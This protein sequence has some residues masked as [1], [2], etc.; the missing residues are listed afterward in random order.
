M[1][2][3]ENQSAQAQLRREVNEL[4]FRNRQLNLEIHGVPLVQGENLHNVLNGVADQL[5]TPHL[6]EHD[7]ASVHRLPAQKDKI[8][9]IIV[10]FTRQS[11]RESWLSK[12]SKLNDSH[13]RIFIQENLTRHN[14]DLLQ[15]T[16][17]WAKE[18]GFKYVWHTHGK[19]LLRM[20]DGANAIHIRSR[21]DL[22]RLLP[23]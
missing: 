12:K 2:E 3:D 6:V 10:R 5:E 13:P 16:K 7:I 9:G 8:P 19:V 11:T 18:A 22:D 17:N 4:E 21:D 23:K 14:R 15:A 20:S 1:K